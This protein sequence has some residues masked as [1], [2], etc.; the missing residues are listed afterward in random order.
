MTEELATVPPGLL[1][2]D[3]VNVRIVVYNGEALSKPSVIM[4]VFADALR[5]HVRVFWPL[6]AKPVV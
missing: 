3:I 6:E 5:E 1:T 4:T 2:V